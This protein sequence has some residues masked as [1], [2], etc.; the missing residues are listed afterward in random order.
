MDG[1]NR[2][3]HHELLL[4]WIGKKKKISMGHTNFLVKVELMWV[5]DHES[6]PSLHED[7]RQT[8]WIILTET[9]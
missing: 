2:L 3:L 5:Q 6:S 7:F 9:K 4:V 8:H 1:E